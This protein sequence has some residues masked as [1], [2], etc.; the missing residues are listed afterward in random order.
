MPRRRLNTKFLVILLVL[1]IAGVAG[2]IAVREYQI[3]RNAPAIRERANTAIEEGGLSNLRDARSL[4]IRYLGH[5]PED[6]EAR[7]LFTDLCFDITELPG[8][9]ESEDFSFALKY[10]PDAV[11]RMPNNNKIRA[12]LVAFYMHPFCVVGRMR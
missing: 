5:R 3:N 11:R 8:N 1:V 6:T 2:A 12:R 10:G 7:T 9:Q 4:L